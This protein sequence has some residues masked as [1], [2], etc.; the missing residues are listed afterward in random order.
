VSTHRS[1]WK[2][3]EREAASLFGAKRQVLSGSSGREDKTCSDST[4][5]KL[6]IETKF[7]A[8]SPVRALWEKTRGL[9]RVE[10]KSPVLALYTKGKPGALLV[11][12]EDDLRA[13]AAE[14]ACAPGPKLQP[15]S[16]CASRP[17]DGGAGNRTCSVDTLSTQT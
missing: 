12:H 15:E 1:T 6:F 10:R 17:A 5:P 14:L 13:V 7:R 11:V 9:A 8:V 3:R 4:H 16:S 2:R